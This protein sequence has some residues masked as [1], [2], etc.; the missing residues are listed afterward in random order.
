LSRAKQ[1]TD[2]WFEFDS[3]LGS[4]DNRKV[5]ARIGKPPGP[6]LP[7][8]HQSSQRGQ[9]LGGCRGRLDDFPGLFCTAVSFGQETAWPR[10]EVSYP[11]VGNNCFSFDDIA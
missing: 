9:P 1:H 10:L 6:H 2:A 11:D 5:L 7:R 4:E 3:L 8:F